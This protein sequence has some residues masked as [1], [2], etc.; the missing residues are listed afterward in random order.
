MKRQVDLETN[1]NGDPK[2]FNT[3]ARSA[4]EHAR[5]LER[6]NGRLEERLKRMNL[7]MAR[8]TK[9]ASLMRGELASLVAAGAALA[10]TFAAAG[11]GAVAFGALAA[12]AIM[13]VVQAQTE[14]GERWA[15][16]A[17]TRRSL[18]LDYGS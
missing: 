5:K 3:A 17:L 6:A 7:Q 4:T 12:P 16:S 11:T 1:I 8:S 10:P 14:M 2:G 18:P 9:S 13:R 15:S